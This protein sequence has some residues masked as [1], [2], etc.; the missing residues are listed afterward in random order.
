VVLGSAGV[1][2]GWTG[3]IPNEAGSRVSNGTDSY[4]TCGTRS[5]KPTRK[6]GRGDILCR[7]GRG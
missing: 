6:V 4:A 3:P 1:D 5:P 7:L 2:G